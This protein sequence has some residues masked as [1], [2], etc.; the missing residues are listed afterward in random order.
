MHWGF[1]GRGLFLAQLKLNKMKKHKR[2]M[3]M[4][5]MIQDIDD[6]VCTIMDK[7]IKKGFVSNNG[8]LFFEDEDLLRTF[9]YHLVELQR[10][11]VDTYDIP[12]TLNNGEHKLEFDFEEYD[13]VKSSTKDQFLADME[14]QDEQ[15]G[16]HKI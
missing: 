7:Y 16:E 3:D 11:I 9:E 4:I 8:E 5:N 10:M 15:F 13:N 14:A 2:K 12:Y 1:G 6:D